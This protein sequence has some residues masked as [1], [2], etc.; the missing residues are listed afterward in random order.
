MSTPEI[1]AMVL[2][3]LTLLV[4]RVLAD[5]AHRTVSA[6]NLALLSHLLDRGSDLHRCLLLVAVRDTTTAEVVR[7][8]L[9]LHPVPG[10][11]ADVVHAH[12][13]A[14]LGEYLVAVLELHSEHGVG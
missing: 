1:R 10:K 14:D 8:E 3:A 12:R 6:D 7:R 4:A 13:P 2:L 11:D 9:D 5:D